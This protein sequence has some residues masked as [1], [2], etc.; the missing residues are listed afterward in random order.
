MRSDT[1]QPHPGRS[2]A[3]TDLSYHKSHYTLCVHLLE[4]QLDARTDGRTDK[5]FYQVVVIND[6]SFKLIFG[7]KIEKKN[8]QDYPNI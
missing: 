3:Y 2:K 7:Q 5:N 6:Q 8:E 4:I 1:L